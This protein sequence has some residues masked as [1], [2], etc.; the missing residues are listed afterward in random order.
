MEKNIEKRSENKII[1]PACLKLL[2]PN[3]SP[4]VCS[5]RPKIKVNTIKSNTDTNNSFSIILVFC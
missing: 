2:L 4:A 1:L 3:S 5:F